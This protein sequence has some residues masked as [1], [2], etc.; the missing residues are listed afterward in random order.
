MVCDSKRTDSFCQ[1]FNDR[2]GL[3]NVSRTFSLDIAVI[4]GQ[5]KIIGFQNEHNQS[6]TNKSRFNGVIPFLHLIVKENFI[7]I[8]LIPVA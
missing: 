4:I 3:E 8:A 2:H 5:R 7:V 6:V 1:F